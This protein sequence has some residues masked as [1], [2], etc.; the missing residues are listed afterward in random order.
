MY[1][2]PRL[3]LIEGLKQ[4]DYKG[5][6]AVSTQHLDDHQTLKEKRTT[7]IF[8]PFYDA[9]EKAVERIKATSLVSPLNSEMT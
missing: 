1:G 6:I 2:D 7:L 5:G 3:S 4:Q 8:L 9:A